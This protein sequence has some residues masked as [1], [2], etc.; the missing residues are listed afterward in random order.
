M[1]SQLNEEDYIREFIIELGTEKSSINFR[2]VLMKKLDLTRNRSVYHPVI[3]PLAWKLI[4]GGVSF[5]VVCVM[6]FIPGGKESITLVQ[7]L[8]EF[9]FFDW[10]V[11]LPTL[12]LPK[13]HFYTV[14]LK[15]LVGFMLLAIIGVVFSIKIRRLT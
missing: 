12:T 14:A 15:S 4:G 10:H 9:S 5:L 13:F 1:K 2:K 6:I 3:S 7:H 8:P 11:Q